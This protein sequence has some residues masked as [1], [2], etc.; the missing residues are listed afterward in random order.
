MLKVVI[1]IKEISYLSADIDYVQY[2][3][4][5]NLTQEKSLLVD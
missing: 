1:K 4:L 2:I 3:M 5:P